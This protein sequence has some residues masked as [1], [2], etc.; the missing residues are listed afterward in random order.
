MAE[1]TQDQ[2]LEIKKI[3]V[4]QYKMK[5]LNWKIVQ[6]IPSIKEKNTLYFLQTSINPKEFELYHADKDGDLAQLLNQN[7][8]EGNYNVQ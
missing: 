3:I 1:F 8:V 7:N 2:I 6:S 5:G 4:D